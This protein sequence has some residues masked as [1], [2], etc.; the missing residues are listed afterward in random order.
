MM[1]VPAE[2]EAY[3]RAEAAARVVAARALA[4]MPR[5]KERPRRGRG[6]WRRVAARVVGFEAIG[7]ESLELPEVPTVGA[8][9]VIAHEACHAYFLGLPPPW[10]LRATND[11]LMRLAR[12]TRVDHEVR[13][14]LTQVRVVELVTGVRLVGPVGLRGFAAGQGVGALLL[15]CHYG[16]DVRRAPEALGRFLDGAHRAGSAAMMRRMR[17]RVERILSARDVK[18]DAAAI[19]ETLRR[20]R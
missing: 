11:A 20:V 18:A 3:C 2:L 5:F 19:V 13:A 10:D 9:M 8:W 14:V 12:R 17:R 16:G 15:E 7:V 4:L 6:L 1:D